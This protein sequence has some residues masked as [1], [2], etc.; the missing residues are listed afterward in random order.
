M[1]FEARIAALTTTIWNRTAAI[2]TERAAVERIRRQR[3]EQRTL[4][5][6]NVAQHVQLR[7]EKLERRIMELEG[8]KTLNEC[9]PID[10]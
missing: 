4:D 8:K 1:S 10:K 7:N 6:E 9:K 3:A 5:I 2:L